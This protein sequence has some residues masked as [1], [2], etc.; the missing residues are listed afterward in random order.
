MFVEAM[1]CSLQ[2]HF[3]KSF[4]FPLVK[5]SFNV[6]EACYGSLNDRWN[7]MVQRKVGALNVESLLLK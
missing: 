5:E 3:R 1:V 4:L 2:C 6:L 7:H